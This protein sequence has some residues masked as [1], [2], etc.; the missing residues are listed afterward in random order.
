MDKFHNK[1]TPPVFLSP[2]SYAASVARFGE[3]KVVRF[4]ELQAR[5]GLPDLGP[6]VAAH[7][8]ALF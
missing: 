8:R 1:R 7:G 6:L 2:D 4:K 3:D 5:F